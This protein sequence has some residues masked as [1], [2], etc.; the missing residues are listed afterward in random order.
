MFTEDF[1]AAIHYVPQVYHIVL[2][3]RFTLET[4]NTISFWSEVS[5]FYTYK[6][7][8]VD[9]HPPKEKL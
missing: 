2:N 9:S 8:S 1:V 5:F 6:I 3:C 7:T 4:D